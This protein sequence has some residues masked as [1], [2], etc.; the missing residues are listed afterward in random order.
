MV[1]GGRGAFIGAVHR[2]ASAL[3][4]RWRLTAGALSSTPARSLASGRELG[5]E[6]VYPDWREMLRRE[7]ALPPYE[8]I[9]A[10]VIVTPNAT[11]FEIASA[12]VRAG[13]NVICDKPMVTSSREARDLM[14]LA[15]K[16]RVVLA[17][18]YNYTGY[19]MVKQAA[20]MVGAGDVGR[21]RKVFVEYHQGWLAAPIERK[22]QKQA[23][24]RT[25]PMIAGP[26][27]TIGD[28]GTHAENLVAT[29]TGLRIES[30]CADL[31]SLVPGRRL[32]DDASVLLRFRGGARGV[33]TVSQVCI[34]DRNGLVLRVHGDRGSL[35]WRQEEPETLAWH[36]ADGS[37]RILTRGGAGLHAS[38][39]RASRLPPGHPEGFIE[40]L[41]NIYVGVA[42]AILA[43]RAGK[44]PTGLGAEFPTVDD[45]ARGVRFIERV[46]AS[47]K[48][49][50]W[51]KF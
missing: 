8:R 2:M 41:A 11:H 46:I 38:A 4:R 23:A 24:W 12:F 30:L 25:D 44:E 50:T 21:I 45:G 5:L 31:A 34:G 51:V 9:D 7:R 26:G 43:R 47:A 15:H 20:A 48:A 1:G 36:R 42:E 28:I 14:S 29:V 19:P 35:A 17:V 37:A 10:V 13:F 27:G 16:R 49:N 18:T 32:D 6:R 40:A 22:G 33:L 3:D 39:R